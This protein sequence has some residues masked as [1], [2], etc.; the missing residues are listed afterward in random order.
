V[1][2]PVVIAGAGPTGL[3]LALGLSRQ[4]VPSIVLEQRPGLSDHSKAPAILA[5]TLEVFRAWGVLEPF[6]A[7][8]TLLRRVQGWV[9]GETA[10]AFTL[11]LG[12]L[13]ELTATPGLLVLPQDRTEALLAAAVDLCDEADLRFGCRVTAFR[14][15]EG[16][17]E[18]DVERLG[19]HRSTLTCEYLVGCD[20]PHSAVR[21]SLGWHLE[22][23]TYESRVMLADV[24]LPDERGDLPF[25]RIAPLS[26]G[27]LAGIRIGPRLW[28]I[29]ATLDPAES[30]ESAGALVH[31]ARQVEQLFGPGPFQPVW[32]SPFHIHCRN[33]PGF[34]SGRVLLAGDAAHLNSPAG[35]QGMNSGIQDAY[36]LSWKLPRALTA[37]P[38]GG[39][40]AEALLA[41]YERER[42]AT[43][44][45]SVDRTTDLLTR[46]GLLPLGPIRSLLLRTMAVLVRQPA[47][48]RLL[49][50][51]LGMLDVCYPESPLLPAGPAPLRRRAPDG[52]VERAD[53]SRCRLFDLWRTEAALLL[54]DGPDGERADADGAGR[55]A[56][57]LPGLRLHRL[58]HPRAAASAGALR[59]RDDAVWQRWRAEPG[60]VALVRPDDFVGWIGRRPR[61]AE[62]AAA[63]RRGLGA[64]DGIPAASAP[65]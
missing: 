48:P 40:D 65:L 44:L 6:L 41:S 13:A 42:R 18:V 39:G 17:V 21:G 8:G 20:G 7:E 36:D 33:S 11:D 55:I 22:G 34:R 45:G 15:A 38:L 24:R 60:M 54:F 53:G 64:G 10:P 4:G 9:V 2:A 49:A 57:S 23:K 19:G 47:V 43:I 30:D 63:V 62:L 59:V 1:D 3:A 58:L 5:R 26:R 31:V 46:I 37:G 32:A 51:R 61:Q 16:G 56:A 52:E 28:R 25:P 14:Q 12:C 29:I 27:V 35:G 50:P